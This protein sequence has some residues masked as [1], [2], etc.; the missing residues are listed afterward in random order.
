MRS[1]F[2]IPVATMAVL[3][4]LAGLYL[5]KYGAGVNTA[6]PTSPVPSSSS[7]TNTSNLSAVAQQE[8][9]DFADYGQAPDFQ[10]ISQ[11]LNSQPLTT[12]G[13]KGKVVL[14]DFWTFSCINCIRTLPYVTRW[15]DTYRNDGL[16]IVGVHTPEFAFE[17]DT[18]NVA[19][20]IKQFN[21]H[22][23][24]AQD[25]YYT[26]WTAYQNE[27]WPAEYLIDKTGRIVYEHFGEGNYDHT[28]NAIRELLG[29]NMN[30]GQMAVGN[31]DQIGSPEMYFGTNR[32]QNL[33]PD[34]SPLL[35]PHNY[36]I[37]QEPALNNFALGGEWQFS[38][39]NAKLIGNQGE[40]KLK[41]HSGKAYIVASSN[42]P[43]N[44]TVTVDGQAQPALTV[45][46]SR[47]YT[48]FDS[49]D[50][51]DHV[52]DIKITGSGFEAFTFTFG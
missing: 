17:K 38:G 13:L 4:L 19:N 46:D 40:I 10:G 31:L 34:Q 36:S 24:V 26:T 29:L 28:E 22:Y 8:K 33:T 5:D 18:G 2:I 12:L 43:V 35:S 15:Y 23:P 1:K 16:V 44:L 51:S 11:W 47:L 6:P 21:I 20:A 48:L 49:S 50:Y 42:N 7:T 25:N 39:E 37:S 52:L 45:K 30:A 27:Y 3:F 41:F 14:I 9:I 32:L